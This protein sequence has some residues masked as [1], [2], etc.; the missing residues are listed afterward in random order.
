VTPGQIWALLD[1]LQP[2]DHVV[3]GSAARLLLGE[4]T[5]VND[6]DICPRIDRANL[7]AAAR[8]L[9]QIGATPCGPRRWDSMYGVRSNTDGGS[10]AELEWRVGQSYRTEQGLLDVVPRPGGVDGIAQLRSRYERLV[11]NTQV[12]QH[13]AVTVRCV[14]AATLTRAAQYA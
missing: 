2:V 14:D 12:V 8:V 5:P 6:L 10:L 9:G 7:E 1:E 3:F 4:D 11:K 13:G